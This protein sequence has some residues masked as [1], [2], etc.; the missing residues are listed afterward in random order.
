MNLALGSINH[1]ATAKKLL[2]TRRKI[3]G[4]YVTLVLVFTAIMLLPAPDH[5]TLVKYHLTSL[6]LRLILLTLIIPEAA[7]WFAAFYGSY[8]LQRYSQLIKESEDGRQIRRLAHGLL[9]LAI[10]L[11]TA[12]IAG[13]ILSI[14]AAHHPG[15]TAASTVTSNYL[16]IIFPLL[17]FIWI[18]RG[19]WGLSE[20][21]KARPSL[22][23]FNLVVIATLLLGIVFCCLI[24]LDHAELRKTYHMS[25]QLVMLT[26]GAP[27]IYMWF[28]GMF[29][30]AELREYSR[31][32]GGIVYRKGWRQ[33]IGGIASIILLS[34]ALQYI[35]TL[36]TWLTSL[37]LAW[38]LLLLYVLLMLLTGAYIVVALG[39]QRLTNIEEV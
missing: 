1:K 7:I 33:L 14:I 29:S 25:P 26:L 20:L 8:K 2:N 9:L 13:G 19:A 3:L 27:Y 21:S 22:R 5:A 6:A 36:T 17:A 39:A 12:A 16:N 30:V 18:S 38:L 23:V 24:V 31:T 10:G 37:S 28:L 4:A 35:S 32:V 15:F 34:I 11:P